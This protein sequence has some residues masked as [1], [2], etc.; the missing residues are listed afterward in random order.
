M[1]GAPACQHRRS[2]RCI[3]TGSAAFLKL[4]FISVGTHSTGTI[5]CNIVLDRDDQIMGIGSAY[6]GYP[7][8]PRSLTKKG[9][10]MIRKIILELW[11]VR[12]FEAHRSKSA[13]ILM[14]S[15]LALVF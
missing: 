5:E 14:V 11:Q 3:W 7:A 12:T 15:R 1:A 4:N 8:G 10:A 13:L 6:S 9:P 2:P